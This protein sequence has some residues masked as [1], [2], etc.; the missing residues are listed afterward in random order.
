ML[1]VY[2]RS[3]ADTVRGRECAACF[4]SSMKGSLSLASAG[5]YGAIVQAK[6]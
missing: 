1:R 3:E 5:L 4:S 6:P 2:E